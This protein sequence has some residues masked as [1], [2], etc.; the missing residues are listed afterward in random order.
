MNCFRAL[1]LHLYYLGSLPQR[2]WAIR[3]VERDGRAPVMVFTYHRV[4]D[5]LANPWT[6]PC[7][8]FARQIDWLRRHLEL[9]SLDEARRRIVSG[10]SPRL[11]GAIT[12]DDG[13]AD[14]CNAAIPLL[15]RE[16][17]PCTYFVTLQNALS[18]EPFPH[19]ARR[20]DRFAPNTIEQLRTMADAGIEIGSHGY[21]HVDLGQITNH[22]EL[23]REIVLSGREL[24][25][26]L[27]RRVRHFSF[28]F[29]M[30]NNVSQEAFDMA[31]AAGYEAAYSAYG[32][33]NYPG[34]D[35]FHIQRIAVDPC[36]IRLKNWASVDPRKHRVRRFV[37]ECPPCSG[38]AC[39]PLNSDRVQGAGFGGQ[40]SGP[41]SVSPVEDGTVTT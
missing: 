26:L 37:V 22:G 31:R 33:Y 32:G 12:F 41:D 28:P 3:R 11:C 34:G 36:T 39:P 1:L 40:G 8:T 6:I 35:G 5:D 7:R 15:V 14:N 29:G 25:G 17:I 20:G 9:V 30:W 16:R 13:Y 2:R 19:D 21:T 38:R 4:A 27:G 10:D 23:H 24:E 18:G